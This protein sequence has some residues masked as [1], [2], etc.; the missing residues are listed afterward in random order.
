MT[1]TFDL[2]L[3]FRLEALL[4][5]VQRGYLIGLSPAGCHAE[6]TFGAHGM[7]VSRSE[8]YRLPKLVE[9]RNGLPLLPAAAYAIATQ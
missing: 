4:L 9:V 6:A 2:N 8:D 7:E 1:I 5:T 3:L